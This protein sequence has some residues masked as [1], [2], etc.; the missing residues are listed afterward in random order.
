MDDE[1]VEIGGLRAEIL[2]TL[3]A[4]RAGTP[5]STDALIDEL[6]AGEPPDGAPTTLR[7]YV[8]RLRSALGPAASIER[9]TGGYVLRVPPETVDVAR[10]EALTR[11]GR[12]LQERGRHRRAAAAL[13][14]ALAEWRGEPLAGLPLDGLLGAEATRLQE[15][16]LNVL[17]QRIEADLD[18][19][20]GAG[21]VG[22]LEALVAQ[23]PFRERLWRH[24]M[25][26]LYRSGRQA[27]A[28]GAYRRAR[29]A[30]DE[31]LG[32][33]PGAELQEL[34]AAILRQDVPAPV[35]ERNRPMH[36]PPLALTTFIG[37]EAELQALRELLFRSRLVTLQGVGG[38]GK[39]RLAT[40]LALRASADLV[41]TVAFVDLAALTD[42]NLV[43]QQALNALG[44][45]EQPD[46]APAITAG[47]E[48]GG[49]DVLLLL[50]NCEHVRDAAAA[51]ASTLL[52]ACPDMRI[53]ATSRELLGI[54]GEAAYPVSPLQ[55]P[56]G[57][58]G[59]E[60]PRASEAV[61]LLVERAALVRHDLRVDDATWATAA[62]ICRDLEGLP[63]AIEI[64]AARTRALS[65]EE[66]ALR[67]E[68]RFRF[69]VSW[70]RLTTAR[71][72]TLL[73]AMDWSY[74]L[75]AP[76]EQRLFTRLSVFPAGA[77]LPS[78][79]DVCLDGDMDL[80]EQMVERL[81]DASLANPIETP[82]GTRYRLLE[83]V[84]QY[85]EERLPPADRDD[86]RRR[87][88]ERARV[89]AIAA[90]L[91]LES[92]SHA[93]R[94]D[95][96][97]EELPTIRAAIQWAAVVDPSLATAIATALERFWSLTHPREGIA[98]LSALLA[99]KDLADEERARLLRCRGGSHY[100]SGD[101]AAGV[102]DYEAALAIHRRLG[103]RAYEAHLLLRLAFEAQ[104]VGDLPGARRMLEDAA[105]I[106]GEERFAPDAYVGLTLES[107]IAFDEGDDDQGF[108]LL[109]RAL[110]RSTDAGDPM[111]R[112]SA[113]HVTAARAVSRGRFADATVASRAAL[114]LAQEI[115]DRY[116]LVETIAILARIA[117]EAGSPRRAGR[118][119][120]GIEG[121]L[122]RRGP[123][124]DFDRAALRAKVAA[125]AG[126]GFEA[127]VAEARALPLDELVAE[128]LSPV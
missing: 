29:A 122:D 124:P 45:E 49:T 51:A 81:V 74:E 57:A 27:D 101:H 3:L 21:L 64:A 89:I 30:L 113:L 25:L 1:P 112:L 94:F 46:E 90:N 115:G 15:L 34:E 35:G 36:E 61:R 54:D 2:L 127:D 39:T 20:G 75:L 63:L 86:L 100:T 53:L 69:L 55:V 24:L 121:E 105:A 70:R 11:E 18:L 10:F 5:V 102:A 67:L 82:F 79:A 19:R 59:N 111:W 48:L 117:A 99:R 83:T 118:L 65:L 128:A 91:S 56:G 71:H 126:N 6:W 92:S 7:S 119:W 23:H 88:A 32:I 33:D 114:L 26:A 95:L 17:E 41:D 37:R 12:E 84:R 66:I 96:A 107:S 78:I 47:R 40:E 87:H 58:D 60:D 62:Q 28:L 72:R 104:R 50:D 43:L 68:D 44:V 73:E 77:T 31:H 109:E 80:A 125:L 106:G 52:Q 97:R 103:Q 110:Q 42:P 123:V 98:T 16:Q 120:G 13:A 76:G 14:K 22:E 38:V 85:A 8:S 93:S 116:S 4:L 108:A 9:L